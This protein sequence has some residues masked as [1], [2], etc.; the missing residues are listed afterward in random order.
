MVIIEVERTFGEW[1][2]LLGEHRWAEVFKK[3]EPGDK[4]RVTQI[5]WC[6][7]NTGRRVEKY[8]ESECLLRCGGCGINS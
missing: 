3:C 8:G 6:E 1:N 4:D 5:F 7:F 2:S